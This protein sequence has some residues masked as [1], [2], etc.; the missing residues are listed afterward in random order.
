M[1]DY[2]SGNG[3]SGAAPPPHSSWCAASFPLIKLPEPA[4]KGALSGCGAGLNTFF[5]HDI[6]LM[7]VSKGFFV[8]IRHEGICRPPVLFACSCLSTVGALFDC[9]GG[10]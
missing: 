2:S 6:F 7:I 3:S 10:M 5:M 1:P 9:V 4:R 8:I